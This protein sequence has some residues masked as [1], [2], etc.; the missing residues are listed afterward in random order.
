MYDQSTEIFHILK[1]TLLIEAFYHMC[2]IFDAKSR[3]F[4]GRREKLESK[5]V[6]T[7]APNTH[8]L[9]HALKLSIPFKIK[10]HIHILFII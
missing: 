4:H 8:T 3:R 9:T 7:F 2:S 10:H 6:D 5:I 1:T